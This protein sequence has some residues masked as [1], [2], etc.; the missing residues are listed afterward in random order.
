MNTLRAALDV[1]VIAML[2]VVMA[3]GLVIARAMRS[4]S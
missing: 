3:I 1:I 2:A 4:L